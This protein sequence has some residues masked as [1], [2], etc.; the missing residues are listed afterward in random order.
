METVKKYYRINRRE[1]CFLKFILEGYEGLALLTTVDPEK[2][3]VVL[4]IAPGCEAEANG[5]MQALQKEIMIE[6]CLPS[7]T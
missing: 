4:K 6:E 3:I 7:M 1:I 5:L 2:G